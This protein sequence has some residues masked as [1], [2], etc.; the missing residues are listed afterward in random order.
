MNPFSNNISPLK[1]LLA[2][3]KY[4]PA[5][6]GL[7]AIAVVSVIINHFNESIL[8]SGYL[9]V[10]MFFVISGFVI[11]CSLLKRNGTD[12]NQFHY[13]FYTR[14]IKRLLP[15]LLFCFVFAGILISLFNPS[16]NDHIV[17][18]LL[19]LIGFSN[20][21]L[22]FNA[23]DYWGD[24]AKLNP[25]T[26]TWS[27]GVEEQFYML[28]PLIIWLSLGKIWSTSRL[29][30][31][32]LI[33]SVLN[34]MS[35]LLF[36]YLS[37]YDPMS[38]YFLLPSRFWEIGAGCT[39]AIYLNIKK[40]RGIIH[41]IISSI[42][43]YFLLAIYGAI[44]FIPLEHA[45]IS[46]V[47][48]VMCTL[49]IILKVKS[50]EE[51][52]TKYSNILTHKVTMYLG[53]ISY[54]LYLWHWVIITISRWT[55][56]INPETIFIQVSL[57]LFFSV[58]SYHL[59][60]KP[61]RASKWRSSR[62][63]K[64]Y[65]SVM[66]FISIALTSNIFLNKNNNAIYLGKDVTQKTKIDFKINKSLTCNKEK[67]HKILT[68]GNSHSNH[69]IPM[70]KRIGKHCNMEILNHKHPDYFVFPNG[71]N[72]KL[73]DIDENLDRLNQGDLL[74]LSSR[75]RYL[76]TIPYMNGRGD[77]WVDHSDE[78]SQFGYGLEN[79]MN[80]L[81]VII[82]KSKDRHLNIIFFLHNVEFDQQVLNYDKGCKVQWFRRK[83]KGCDVS[84]SRKFLDSRFP[85]EFFVQIY[86]KEAESS[87]FFVFDPLPIF[88]EKSENCSRI[89]NGVV[90]FKDTNHLTQEGSLLM[91]DEFS[92][93]LSDNKLLTYN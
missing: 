76:Y 50:G 31:V 58:F 20:F 63:V 64:I 14:R 32:F 68:I 40:T 41:L 47:A 82:E 87:N 11:T 71:K 17:T 38:A 53:A 92:L 48:I 89:V 54:S 46:T 67:K 4:S 52:D 1:T 29:K 59:I 86:E 7:R 39:L 83:P 25:Y 18:G 30:L 85:R 24:S 2:V 91:L 10:D 27:L 51:S 44:F 62:Q 26:H 35:L 45:A 90:A 88:C 19:S 77:R 9:G 13:G 8:P 80:E 36:I 33:L 69:I 61:L 42:P 78:K 66:I 43:I 72:L 3:N 37:T 28:F 5:I 34:V 57:I 12:I 70:L 75:N 16:P 73:D 84:V 23:I 60:E 79:W 55:I 81:D 65:F 6:E 93:F 22:Y 49:L 56:G 15:A 21:D 74:I